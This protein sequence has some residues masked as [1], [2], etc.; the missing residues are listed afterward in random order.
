MS[1][2]PLSVP[3]I[4]ISDL[5]SNTHALAELDS[6]CRDW[7]FFQVT[8]HGIDDSLLGQVHEQMRAFFARTRAEKARILRTRSNVWGYYDRELTKNTR[9]WKEIFDVGN[10]EAEGPVA[11]ASPQWPAAHG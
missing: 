9:D 8:N 6:A 3:V 2:L 5:A 7:G 10:E 11:G 4:E 1:D